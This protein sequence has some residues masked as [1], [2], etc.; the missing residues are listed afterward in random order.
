MWELLSE[1]MHAVDMDMA[2]PRTPGFQAHEEMAKQP[3]L[4]LPPARVRL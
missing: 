2:M 4:P 1:W 3:T